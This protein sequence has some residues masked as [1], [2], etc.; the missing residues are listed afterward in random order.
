MGIIE[1]LIPILVC[2]MLIGS[3]NSTLF[4]ASRYMLA[5]ASK[6]QLPTFLFCTNYLHDSPRVA[7][8]FQVNLN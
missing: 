6:R 8:L 4:V 1:P 3:L 2:V 7:L 5:A